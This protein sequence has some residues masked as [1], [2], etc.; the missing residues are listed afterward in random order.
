MQSLKSLN[1]D[2]S[3]IKKYT[4]SKKYSEIGDQSCKNSPGEDISHFSNMSLNKDKADVDNEKSE[5]SLGNS[6][7]N[8]KV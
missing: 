5:N 8:K 7:K 2:G 4:N 1:K 6:T 3:L